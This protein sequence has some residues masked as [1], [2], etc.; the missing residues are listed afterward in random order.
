MKPPETAPP[1]SNSSSRT[2]Q[3]IS[4]REGQQAEVV[5]ADKSYAS[6]E[7]VTKA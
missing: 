4:L 2:A 3:A 1:K 7:I 5:I 6:A